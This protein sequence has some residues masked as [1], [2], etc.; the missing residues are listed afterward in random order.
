M[1]MKK[2]TVYDYENHTT[3]FVGPIKIFISQPFTGYE[4]EEVIKI[5]KAAEE[6]ILA[7]YKTY[8]NDYPYAVF[9]NSLE[10][11]DVDDPLKGLALAIAYLSE[12]DIAYFVV[13]TTDEGVSDCIYTSRGCGIEYKI[14]KDYGIP[15]ASIY[16]KL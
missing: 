9:L 2:Y 16:I 12:A 4:K 14:C 3:K 8:D 13:T 11:F 10:C 6:S 7:R 1:R 5:R 15:T